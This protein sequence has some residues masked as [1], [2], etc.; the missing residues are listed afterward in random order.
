MM[1]AMKGIVKMSRI[2]RREMF[3]LKN[4]T[5][6]KWDKQKILI[7]LHTSRSR[8]IW[9]SSPVTEAKNGLG[10]RLGLGLGLGLGTV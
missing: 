8:Y 7:R 9:F 4:K 1:T 10:L 6:R 3:S 2:A 5:E